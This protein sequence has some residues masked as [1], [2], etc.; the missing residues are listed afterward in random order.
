MIDHE[1]PL[2]Q[3]FGKLIER[4]FSAACMRQIQDKAPIYFSS[5]N[6]YSDDHFLDNEIFNKFYLEYKST[7]LE[8]FGHKLYVYLIRLGPAKLAYEYLNL[9]GEIRMDFRCLE[10]YVYT[11][12]SSF[13]LLK[14]SLGGYDTGEIGGLYIGRWPIGMEEKYEE[15]YEKIDQALNDLEHKIFL[16][17]L[18]YQP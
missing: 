6:D 16:S 4:A 2:R 13:E 12:I 8:T 5:E 7:E 17:T 10:P 14:E 15:N 1:H 18:S 11:K 3:R 9:A